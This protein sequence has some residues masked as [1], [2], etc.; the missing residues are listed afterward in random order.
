MPKSPRLK[1]SQAAAERSRHMKRARPRGGEDDPFPADAARPSRLSRMRQSERIKRA[2]RQRDM[3]KHG[4]E[5][6]RDME[7]NRTGQSI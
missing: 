4:Y 2:R 7:E 5:T 6:I 3:L 1:R